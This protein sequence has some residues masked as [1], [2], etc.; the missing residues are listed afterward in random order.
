M[1][2]IFMAFGLVLALFFSGPGPAEAQETD[3]QGVIASQI[4]AF[5]ADDFV[6]AFT[7][8]APSIQNIFRTPENFGRMVSQGYPMVW[9]PAEVDY[10]DLRREGDRVFQDVQIVDGAGRTHLLEYQMTEMNGVWKISGV[11]LLKAPG[12]AA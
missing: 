12:V 10:L 5:K 9:R 4:D 11:R 6:T 3:I 7:F 2:A 8:A 1:R